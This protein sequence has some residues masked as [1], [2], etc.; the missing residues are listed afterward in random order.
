MKFFK[1]FLLFVPVLFFSCNDSSNS[2]EDNTNN[3]VYEYREMMRD[4]VK[5]ISNYIKGK[6]QDFIVIGQNGI[7]LFTEDGTEKSHIRYDYLN[8]LD[9]V[10]QEGLFYGYDD[11]DKK[12]DEKVSKHLQKLLLIAKDENKP[13]LITDYCDDEEKINDSYQKNK[14]L[15]FISFQADSLDLDKIP[16]YPPYPWDEN[17][18]NISILSGA[19]NYLYLLDFHKFSSKDELLNTLK[20]T[21]YDVL[22][23]DAFWDT[24]E[25]FSIDDIQSLKTKANGGRRLVIAYLS[26]GE[27]EDNRW[28]WQEEWNSNLPDWIKDYQEWEGNYPVE[29]WNNQ[30]KDIVYTYIDKIINN[31]F[32]GVFLD[33]IDIYEFFEEYHE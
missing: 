30:W 29:F 28:Y 23:I 25:E 16:D 11:F 31:G 27:A 6:K 13:V 5:E 17:P 33:K 10:S 15:G 3:T 8:A 1:I 22:I 9:G 18:D 32:D 14:N 19:K 7:E 21:N 12:T 2:S 4:F 26:I 20:N 24:Y